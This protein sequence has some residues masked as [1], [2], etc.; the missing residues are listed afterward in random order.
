MT[1]L[2]ILTV[3]N[4]EDLAKLRRQALPVDFVMMDPSDRADLKEL[5]EDLL[6]TMYR[7]PNCVGLAASQVGSNYRV[8]AMDCSRTKTRPEVMINP[9]IVS[10]TGQ[11][12]CDEACLSVPGVKRSV[13]R[14]KI[15]KVTWQ[16]LGGERHVG[17]FRGIDAV[18]IQHEIDH[19]DGVLFTDRAA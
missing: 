16:G 17:K 1:T 15:I 14:A 18:V 3:D 10:R 19:L 9:E 8:L 2:R 12:R 11:Q 4:P 6:E 5:L 13:V 7:A